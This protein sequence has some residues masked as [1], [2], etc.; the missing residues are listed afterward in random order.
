M[1]RNPQWC[2]PWPW[3]QLVPCESPGTLAGEVL[4]GPDGEGVAGDAAGDGTADGVAAG[5]VA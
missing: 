4:A 2:L 3:P 1:T 5:A